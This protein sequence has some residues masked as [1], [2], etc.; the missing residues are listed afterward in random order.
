MCGCFKFGRESVVTIASPGVHCARK[1][2]PWLSQRVER[3]ARV[4]LHHCCAAAAAA[5]AAPAAPAAP[6]AVRL[7]SF[8]CDRG[9][10]V[11]SVIPRTFGFISSGPSNN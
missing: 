6:A 3:E 1:R 7:L 5:A 10:A 4:L 8:S 2:A 11:D 9:C